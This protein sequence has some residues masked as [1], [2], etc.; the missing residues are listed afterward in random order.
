[1]PVC[2]DELTIKIK[3]SLCVAILLLLYNIIEGLNENVEI[4]KITHPIII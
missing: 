2:R 3:T 4:K 1:M